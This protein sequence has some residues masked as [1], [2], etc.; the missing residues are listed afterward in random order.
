MPDRTEELREL[1]EREAALDLGRRILAEDRTPAEVAALAA[2]IGTDFS[3]LQKVAAAMVQ[4][5][6]TLTAGGIPNATAA[7]MTGH[8][9]R[10]VL[11]AARERA[12]APARPLG[13]AERPPTA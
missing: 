2:E 6:G 13:P 9:L 5:F 10:A 3:G 4:F 11:A 1:R 7:E 8:A 12:K